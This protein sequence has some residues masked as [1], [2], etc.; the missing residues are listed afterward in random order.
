MTFHARR[1]A[2][3][4][5]FCIETAHCNTSQNKTVKPGWILRDKIF[6]Y[7]T[8]FP[9]M[10]GERKT[11]QQKHGPART[12]GAQVKHTWRWKQHTHTQTQCIDLCLQRHLH[13][14]FLFFSYN[15]HCPQQICFFPQLLKNQM[16]NIGLQRE[17]KWHRAKFSIR[18]LFFLF[19][20]FPVPLAVKVARTPAVLLT[21]QRQLPSVCFCDT[22]MVLLCT[23]TRTHICKKKE[24]KNTTQHLGKWKAEG[25]EGVGHLTLPLGF[26]LA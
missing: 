11:N 8:A 21:S 25:R 14:Y 13:G 1:L 26:P 3:Q 5:L 4:K 24:K 9:P 17:K 7:R 20:S 18:S 23:I 16:C 12:H 10:W 19:L 15:K 2:W 6:I 22:I